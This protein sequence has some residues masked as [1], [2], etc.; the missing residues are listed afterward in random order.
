MTGS[1]DGFNHASYILLSTSSWENTEWNSTVRFAGST[2]NDTNEQFVTLQS[3]V[4]TPVVRDHNYKVICIGLN[5]RLGDIIPSAIYISTDSTGESLILSPTDPN[6][7]AYNRAIFYTHVHQRRF[8]YGSMSIGDGEDAAVSQGGR[9]RFR[10]LSLNFSPVNLSFIPSDIY[11][12][13]MHQLRRV[14]ASVSI[15]HSRYIRF[16]NC[17]DELVPLLPN[18]K[19]R[20]AHDSDGLVESGEIVL[21]AADYLERMANPYTCKLMVARAHEDSSIG[22]Y[23]ALIRKIGGIHFDYS[24]NRIGFFDPL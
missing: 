7:Y 3:V 13:F 23:D 11:D 10:R 20:L 16:D 19:F 12:E 6:E 22:L 18:I 2:L 9:R 15:Y 4:D 1:T 8:I 5:G 21:T 24:N 14:G 17:Y